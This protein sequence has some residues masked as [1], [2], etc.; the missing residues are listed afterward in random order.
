MILMIARDEDVMMKHSALLYRRKTVRCSHLREAEQRIWSRGPGGLRYPGVD[1]RRCRW[2]ITPHHEDV[3]HN[4][5]QPQWLGSGIGHVDATLYTK[6][7]GV[8]L[9][10]RFETLQGLRQA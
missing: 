2:D 8:E 1:E 3:R 9:R 10:R 4:S 5:E 6:Q 7:H